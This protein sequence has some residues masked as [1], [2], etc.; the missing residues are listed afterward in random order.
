MARPCVDKGCGV[1]KGFMEGWGWSVIAETQILSALFNPHTF[2]NL[3]VKPWYKHSL[4]LFVAQC[5]LAIIYMY[6]FILWWHVICWQTAFCPLPHPS[7]NAHI[8]KWSSQSNWVLLTQGKEGFKYAVNYRSVG[9]SSKIKHEFLFRLF[10]SNSPMC[11]PYCQ[12]SD[13]SINLYVNVPH[14]VKT[15][16]Q[17]L[18]IVWL[19]GSH[20]YLQGPS[21]VMC[22]IV[23]W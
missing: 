1:W 18:P 8:F 16:V 5:T 13:R 3:N 12:W 19:A 20:K 21:L 11:A 9:D 10:L 7:P 22:S 14:S 2:L 23:L 4:F 17:H 6:F 15:C